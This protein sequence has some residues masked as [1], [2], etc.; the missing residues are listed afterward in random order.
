MTDREEEWINAYLNGEISAENFASLQQRLA[1]SSQLRK[2][3]RKYLAVVNHLERE[4]LVESP[5]TSEKQS[6]RCCWTI[7]LLAIHPTW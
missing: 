7:A 5:L 1:E 4:A 6:R 2:E 3:L